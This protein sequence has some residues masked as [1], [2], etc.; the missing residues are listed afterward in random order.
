LLSGLDGPLESEAVQGWG[1]DYDLPRDGRL[2]VA[3]SLAEE[4]RRDVAEL[5][6]GVVTDGLLDGPPVAGVLADDLRVVRG[7]R[8]AAQGVE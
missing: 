7:T 8:G 2:A 4:A 6:R 5:A 3:D 1:L